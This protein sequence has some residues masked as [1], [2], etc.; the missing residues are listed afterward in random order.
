MKIYPHASTDV[1]HKTSN[2]T[3]SRCFFADD[4]KEMDKSDKTHV[5]GCKA[6]VFS[7]ALNMQILTFL[8]PSPL[9]LLKDLKLPNV[10]R[11]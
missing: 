8:L 9:S 11:G 3:I 6:I 2:W 1:L 5:Q 10:K 4:G 7:P